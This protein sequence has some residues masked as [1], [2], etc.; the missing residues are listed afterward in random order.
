MGQ[1]A[2]RTLPA[3]QRWGLLNGVWPFSRTGY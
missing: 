3:V 1:I 2:M